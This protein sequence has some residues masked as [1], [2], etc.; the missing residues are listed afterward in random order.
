MAPPVG[1]AHIRYSNQKRAISPQILFPFPSPY[2]PSPPTSH[3]SR[4]PKL[5]PRFVTS[6][7][8]SLSSPA[9]GQPHRSDCPRLVNPTRSDSS[10]F[11][12][13]THWMPGNPEARPQSIGVHVEAV[14]LPHCVSLMCAAKRLRDIPDL[15]MFR[16]FYDMFRRFSRSVVSNSW[17][18]V[19]RSPPGSSVHGILQAR[20]LQCVA[21]A[22]SNDMF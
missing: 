4:K 2:M 18:P 17:D 3:S 6:S 21:I 8:R 9:Q 22:F 1:F 5:Q 19:D 12:P 20:I 7:P 16:T 10:V 14:D 13:R 15:S 11:V